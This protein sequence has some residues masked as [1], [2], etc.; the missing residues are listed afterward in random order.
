MI[1]EI[2]EK[3][4]NG[5]IAY[6]LSNL[7]FRCKCNN[8]DC[9]YTLFSPKL[10]KSWHLTR[11]TWGRP[12]KV[13][14]G[15]RCQKHNEAVGGVDK[16]RHMLGEAIDISHSQFNIQD[17]NKL[18]EILERFFDVVLEYETFYHYHNN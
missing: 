17:K 15:F 11:A 3:E 14:S 7:E 5:E 9:N 18:K 10:S 13:N 2:I 16:S 4:F 6:K 8:K 12:L 1:I